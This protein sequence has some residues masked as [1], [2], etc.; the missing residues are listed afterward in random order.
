MGITTEELLAYYDKIKGLTDKKTA[1]SIE[2]TLCLE[3]VKGVNAM[4]NKRWSNDV[5]VN[6]AR[7]LRK[8]EQRKMFSPPED[9]EFVNKN[10][11]FINFS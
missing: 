10:R 4:L 7:L 5:V 9:K 2:Q 1:E 3:G 11:T 8:Y 6:E